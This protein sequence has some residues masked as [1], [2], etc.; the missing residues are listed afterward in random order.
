MNL[1]C[2]S[3]NINFSVPGFRVQWKF[4]VDAPPE[5]IMYKLETRNYFYPANV[6]AYDNSY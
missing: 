4:E 3:I 1:G 5:K 6:V 2:H